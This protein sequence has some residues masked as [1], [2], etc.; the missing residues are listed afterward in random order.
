V[1]VCVC[2]CVRL[3]CTAFST[4]PAGA[5]AIYPFPLLSLT[6]KV[7]HFLLQRGESVFDLARE[8]IQANRLSE[9]SVAVTLSALYVSQASRAQSEQGWRAWSEDTF[10][11]FARLAETALLGKLLLEVRPVCLCA[12]FLVC[13]VFCARFADCTGGAPQRRHLCPRN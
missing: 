12:C 8:F 2:V 9:V 13:R 7:L 5:S 11:A 4:Q 3:V 1:C 6:A 10:A